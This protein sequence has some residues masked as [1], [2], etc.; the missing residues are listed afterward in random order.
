MK[1][2]EQKLRIVLNT[3]AT[4]SLLSGIFLLAFT[5]P[6][7]HLFGVNEPLVFQLIGGGLLFFALTVYFQ[8][9]RKQ[10]NSKQIL[11]INYQDWGWVLGS[12]VLLIGQFFGISIAGQVLIGAVAILIAVFALLQKKYLD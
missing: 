4:F 12:M 2:T 8:A 11:F 5:K 10:L 7:V 6:I 3:N 1:T 9:S